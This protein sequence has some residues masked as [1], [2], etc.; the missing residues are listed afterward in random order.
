MSCFPDSSFRF[1]N[2]D[3]C[4]EALMLEEVKKA[5]IIIP[6]AAIV[7]APACDR[8]PFLATAVNR[9]AIS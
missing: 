7:G 2:G 1:V 4:N 8:E 9:N 5:D 3:V 6:L